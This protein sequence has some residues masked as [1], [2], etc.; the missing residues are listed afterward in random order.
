MRRESHPAALSTYTSTASMLLLA[1]LQF[2]LK[3]ST[4]KYVKTP[5]IHKF[6]EVAMD[7][8][9]VSQ[10]GQLQP[11]TMQAF[12]VKGK[13]ILVANVAGK[14][15]AIGKKCSHMGGDLSKG[16]LAGT[17]VTCPRHKSQFDVTSGKRLAGPAKS[18]QPV[19]T[20]KIE[21]TA[22]KVGI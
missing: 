13:E 17:V 16:K 5:Y 2:I 19:Y 14:Y 10:E 20:I 11:G 7:F 22:I 18:D 1:N 12:S 6:M 8:I 4:D 3:E 9:E 21:G 15:Y